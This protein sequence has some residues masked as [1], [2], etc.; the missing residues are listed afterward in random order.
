M[1]RIT[2]FERGARGL[3]VMWLCEEMGLPYEFV[4]ETWPTS[5][6]YRAKNPLGS[7][8]FLE[9]GAVAINESAAMLL[10]VAAK[11]GPT[12]LLPEKDD[13][14]FARVLQMTV[15]SEASFGAGMNVL[16]AAHFGAPEADKKNWSQRVQDQVSEKSLAFIEGVLGDQPYLAGAD[17]TLADIA[18][19]TSLGVWVGALGKTLPDKLIAYRQRLADRPAY[20]RAREKNEAKG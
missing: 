17:V 18:I 8:P 4:R 16:M 19:A 3:R 6:A 10:Y 11:Y 9:D 20:K 7:V 14:R 1:I 12:P 15:F 5:D 2:N 13:P